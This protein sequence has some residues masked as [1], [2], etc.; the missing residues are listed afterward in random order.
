MSRKIALD[1]INLKMEERVAHTEYSMEY[2]KEYITKITTLNEEHPERFKKFYQ[3][4]E[5]D[6]LWCTD[7]G[8]FGN[9][10]ERGRATDMGH[11]IYAKD[12]SDKRDKKV[13]PFKDVFEVWEFDPAKEYGFPDFNEQVNAYQKKYKSL[14][15]NFPEQLITGG[16]YKTIISGLIQTFGWEMLLLSAS[17]LNKFEKLIDRFFNYTLFYMRA[18]AKTD[19]EV[20]IQ[21]DD[22][23][24][25]SG[26]F[27]SP[28]FYRKAIIPK[29]GQLWKELKK[30]GKKILFCS[31]GNYSMFAKD[32][33]E[34]GADGLIFEP[35]CDFGFMVENFGTS[36]CLVGSY[37]DCRDMTMG[38]WEKVKNDIDKTLNYVKNR[39]CK[40]LIF[41]VGNHIPANITDE[42][43][44]KYIKYLK[45]K[46]I[47]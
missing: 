9:W 45:E 47:L 25:Y 39:K 15:E 32:I 16:Y 29:Y 18:W 28:D 31:D 23:V 19:V 30:N 22:F 38:K 10:L 7:D 5:Y 4:W 33:I 26:P 34:V 17:D 11:A 8:L 13:C 27:I 46:L 1:A 24:W 20:I 36:V 21:H 41:A 12:G 35:V 37:V 40:G 42:M 14:S 6:L 43:C 44:D 2:H 3:I